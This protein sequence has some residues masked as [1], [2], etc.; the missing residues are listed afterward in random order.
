MEEKIK[1][2]VEAFDSVMSKLSD[3]GRLDQETAQA[4]MKAKTQSIMAIKD[5]K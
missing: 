3:E 1:A 5:G 4:L 2:I